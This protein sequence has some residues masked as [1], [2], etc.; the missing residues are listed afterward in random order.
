[1]AEPRENGR[2]APPAYQ[3]YAADLLADRSFRSMSAAERGVLFSMRLECWTNRSVPCNPLEL[4]RVLGLQ[5]SEVTEGLTAR[6]LR[7]FEAQEGPER[8]LVCPQLDDYRRQ[9]D[10]RHSRMSAGGRKGADHTNHSR[11]DRANQSDN[12]HPDGH[13]VSH[14]TARPD[15][16][17]ACNQTAHPDGALSKEETSPAEKSKDKLVDDGHTDF[18]DAMSGPAPFEEAAARR[19]KSFNSLKESA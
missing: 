5:E 12:A 7:Y 11:R 6:V 2:R 17:P 15:G 14:Q 10:E 1:M 4:A 16:H 19:R 8:V 18:R 13:P 9:L 3:E